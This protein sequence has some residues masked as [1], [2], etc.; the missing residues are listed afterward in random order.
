MLSEQ[1]I[2]IVKSTVPVLEVKG[3]EITTV[4]YK[5]MFKKHPELL[6]IFNHANQQQGR[7]QAALANT[8]YAAAKNIDQLHVLIP[9]VKQ[10]A[11]KHRSLAIKPE[12]YPIVGES[13]LGAIKEVLGDAATD[14]II[15]AWAEAY[16]VIADV[17]INVEKEMYQE[18][19]EQKG[20]WIDY[21]D[22]IVAD[23]VKESD[24][25]TSFY[26]KPADGGE[27]ASF[28]PGQYITI[29]LKMAGEKFM[30]NRQY[31]LSHMPGNE[32]YR[33]S[34]KREA[35]PDTPEGRVSNY[36]HDKVQAGDI[37]EAT[38]P[39]GDFILDQNDHNP[40]YLISGGVGI[41]PFM[42]M[43][44][45]IA[46][47]QPEREV[48][49]IHAAR[50]GN[51]QA[52]KE[53]LANLKGDLKNFK[54]SYIYEDPTEADLQNSHFSKQGY[55]DKQWFSENVKDKQ[56]Q[57]HVCGPVPFLRAVVLGLRDFGVEQDHIHYE[58]F[59]PAL[60]LEEN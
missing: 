34:V 39:A 6:H 27:I 43:I 46:N 16:G 32:H 58:F 44:H 35:E 49:F 55:I 51:V 7:Q 42:S 59:G 30:V 41:T 47:E 2:K 26:L 36:L 25:I 24:V 37:I 52:F 8:V 10:I 31:S 5:N 60:N 29:R 48:H 12:H 53:E 18:A 50:N 21:R 3:T 57:F 38:A 17:F 54:L 1:T 22:F 11:H 56:G 40:V 45:W 23:K 20:G 13:L 28:L 9:A 19:A 33:I 14:E 15:N 4:F